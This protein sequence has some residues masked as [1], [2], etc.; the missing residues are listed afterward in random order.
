MNV[1]EAS[2]ALLAVKE[3]TL[4][5]IDRSLT[6]MMSQ[7]ITLVPSQA[8]PLSLEIIKSTKQGDTKEGTSALETSKDNQLGKLKTKLWSE[9][10]KLRIENKQLEEKVKEKAER[11]VVKRLE[12]KQKCKEFK[13][14][15]DKYSIIL[16]DAK[17]KEKEHLI[18]QVKLLKE[19]VT[20]E[21]AARL[22]WKG[23]HRSPVRDGQAEGRLRVKSLPGTLEVI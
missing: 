1:T 13:S 15:E 5:E 4:H 6:G 23:G 16:K 3:A 22:G 12:L 18:Q 11:N 20:G 8:Q 9:V 7:R 17:L 2:K 21:I 19:S 14:T 10:L